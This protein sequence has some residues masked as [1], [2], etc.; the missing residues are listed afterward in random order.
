MEEI[1][2]TIMLESFED[3]FSE[4][5]SETTNVTNDSRD[6]HLAVFEIAT[7][8]LIFVLIVFGNSCVLVALIMRKLKMNRMYYF[9]LHLCIADLITA[10]FNV[11][12]QFAWDLTH[13]F[14]GGNFLCKSI[15]YLQMLGPYLSSYVLV[16][17]SIDRYQAICY[18][19]SNCAW[20]PKRSQLMISF[21]WIIALLC[22]IPQVFIFSY[23]L[24]PNSNNVYD[25][26]GTFPQPFGERIYVTWYAIS[27]FFVPF[28]LLTVTHVCIC[29]EIW[30]NVHQK[31]KSVKIEQNKIFQNDETDRVSSCSNNDSI[32]RSTNVLVTVG[33]SYRFKGRGRVEVS[34]DGSKSG[35]S[36]NPRS[37]SLNGLSRAKIKTVKITIVVIL[38]YIICS[39]PFICAQLWA[40]W[41]P[42]AQQSPFW[43]GKYFIIQF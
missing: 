31:R 43:S 24:I 13:R 9:L 18:P 41:W 11:L 14:Y 4:T 10:F 35:G 2:T 28:I 5:T 26:W 23:Q 16:M 27:F 17:T 30:R 32:G 15:K 34:I 36:Y 37:H 6:E 3:K 33:R 22:C 25:C 42:E 21:A 1:G 39:S 38:C 20:T 29:R 7:L 12:P 19:L 8:G 40:Y